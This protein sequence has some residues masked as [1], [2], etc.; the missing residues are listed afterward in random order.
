MFT[1]EL[2][3]THYGMFRCFFCNIWFEGLEVEAV[4]REDGKFVD[5]VCTDC[6]NL[7]TERLASLVRQQVVQLRQRAAELDAL[8]ATGLPALP[9]AA[10]RLCLVNMMPRASFR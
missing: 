1:V 4:A 9:S 2:E 7:D 5:S 6:L 8:L 10:D 3:A